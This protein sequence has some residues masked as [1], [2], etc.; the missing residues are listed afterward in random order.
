M[1][2]LEQS[3]VTPLAGTEGAYAP[4]FS[5][6]GQWVGFFA[7]G[8]LKKTSLEGGQPVTLCD[9]PAGRGA[10]WGENGMIVAALDIRVGLSLVSE[11][12]GAVSPVTALGPAELSHRWPQMLPGG[13]AVLFTVG[14]VP[15]NYEAAAIAVASLENNPEKAKKVILARAGLSPR[16]LPTGHVVYVTKGTLYAVRFDLDRL[17]TLGT[18][19]PV[20][21]ELSAD[22][23][24]GSAQLDFSRSGMVLYRSARTTGLRV[25]QWLS[26]NGQTEALWAEPAFY[27]MPQVSPD[28]SRLASVLTDGPNADIWVYEWQRGSRTRLTGGS[29][30]N[31]FPLWTPD[32]QYVVFQSDGRLVW[33]RADG[34]ERPQRL[35]DSEKQQFPTSFSPDGKRLLL[36]EHSSDGGTLI[37]TM[38]IENRS[39]Q[40]RAGPAELFRRTP[41]T[42]P[43]PTFSHDGRWVAYASAESGVYEVYVRAFPDDGRQ[44]AISTEGGSFPVWSRTTNE[45]FYR[46]EDQLLMVTSY[47]VVGNSFVAG[48]PRVWSDRRLSNT[49]LTLNFDVAPDGKRFAALMP[50][51]SSVPREPQRHVMLV[52]NFF[53]ELRRLAPTN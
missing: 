19:T 32:G 33:T 12:G 28:G 50:L 3:E 45:L 22:I 34:A 14:S 53:D 9:A 39:G 15:S 37:Q 47:T 6:D 40:L 13:N 52:L 5:P 43:T 7:G 10:S 51:E 42:N 18:A 24:F 25:V 26:G 36:Y 48:K 8:K 27:Q 31:T 49:G 1:R 29:G 23:N 2:R 17:E 35:S 30:V 11:D 21:D 16:Y 20:L 41:S 38:S 44:W 4:F 46:T